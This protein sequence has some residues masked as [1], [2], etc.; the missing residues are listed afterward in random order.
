MAALAGAFTAGDTGCVLLRLDALP[1]VVRA[2][3]G[4][5][6]ERLRALL[7][8]N[9]DPESPD[10][11]RQTLL[12]HVSH[13]GCLE[14]AALLIERRANVNATCRYNGFATS[15]VCPIHMAASTGQTEVVQLL[16]DHGASINARDSAG[17]TPLYCAATAVKPD[18][19]EVLLENRADPDIRTITGNS[20]LHA[21]TTQ[22]HRCAEILLRHGANP[23]INEATGRRPLN[24]AALRRCHVV[25]ELLIEHGADVNYQN[26]GDYSNFTAAAVFGNV[27]MAQLLIN[28]GA[29]RPELKPPIHPTERNAVRDMLDRTTGTCFHCMWYTSEIIT[30]LCTGFRWC[31]RRHK[32]TPRAMRQVIETVVV[33]R[34]IDPP[35]V[36][37][38]MP[39]E[40]LFAIFEL[41]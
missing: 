4:G 27:Q 12:H 6:T 39:N 28:Y 37:H 26:A 8:L 36:W 20:A 3:V 18:V 30:R 11:S 32:W 22:D 7:D 16:L 14:T 1:E 10:E 2:A 35:C 31:V 24:L 19:I 13:F 17:R 23:N 33:L 34:A 38:T 25:A 15:N 21:S 40:L 29:E 41:L 9:A 5:D